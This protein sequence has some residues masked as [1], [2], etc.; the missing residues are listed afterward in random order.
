MF[1]GDHPITASAVARQVGLLGS[2]EKVESRRNRSSM[3]TFRESQ[4][5]E[6]ICLSVVHG[7]EINNMTDAEWDEVLNRKYVVFART[8]PEQKLNIV[9]QCQK[10]K[11]IVAVTGIDR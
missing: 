11:E 6:E 9:E 2:P 3:I 1:S 8:T 7:E 10:R 5:T 4:Q